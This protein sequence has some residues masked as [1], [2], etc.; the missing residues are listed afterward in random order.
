M[1][2]EILI[3]FLVGLIA[4]VL[5]ALLTVFITLRVRDRA[6]RTDDSVRK[7]RTGK[8]SGRGK[9]GGAKGGVE[10]RQG[11]YTLRLRDTRPS[12]KVWTYQIDDELIIGR[13][14]DCDLQLSDKSVSRLHCKIVVGEYGL[15]VADLGAKHRTKQ[16]GV[17][18][19]SGSPLKR[20][21]TLRLGQEELLVESIRHLGREEP[22][23]NRKN[24]DSS[25]ETADNYVEER[26]RA[27]QKNSSVR[28]SSD[29]QPASP[30]NA[31]Q[32]DNWNRSENREQEADQ[33]EEDRRRERSQ[34]VKDNSDTKGVW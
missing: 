5:I 9:R 34:S 15:E 19:F 16:N 17:F 6:D 30:W 33:R 11:E 31:A 24:E 29:T 28:K 23:E 13:G 12:G 22:A 2:V 27:P 1:S 32:A 25:D 21:D 18:V 26:E 14:E 7:G 8:K 3:A 4:A 10:E 20:G